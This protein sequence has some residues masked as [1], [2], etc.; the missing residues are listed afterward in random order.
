DRRLDALPAQRPGGGGVEHRDADPRRLVGA[1]AALL[2]QLP[3]GLVGPGGGGRPD[4]RRRPPLPGDR[5]SA[6]VRV[7]P[8]A[9]D[10]P[11]AAAEVFTAALALPPGGGKT[12]SV[13]LSGGS[14]PRALFSLLA[15]PAAPY[16]ARIAW[17]AIHFFWGDE[18][19]V[20][21]DDAES[22]FR[23]A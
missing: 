14:T 20:P 10:L 16:R 12:P 3:R 7:L 17:E 18:R 13:L 11:A 9:A 8:A 5:M 2:P 15:D 22:N 21:P 23:M 4:P 1:R 19:H 6:E